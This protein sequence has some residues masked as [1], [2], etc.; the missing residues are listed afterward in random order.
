MIFETGEA[1]SSRDSIVELEE[2]IADQ[3]TKCERCRQ[4][5]G[6]AK[7]S[8]IFGLLLLGLYAAGLPYRSA[9]MFLVGTAA[10]LGG[11]V[12]WGSNRTTWEQAKAR[13]GALEQRRNELIDAT[14]LSLV[15]RDH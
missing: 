14:E 1:G 12:L 6:L 13:L 9:L 2:A 11:I 5:A 4:L 3:E 8:L 7:G 10:T 15:R